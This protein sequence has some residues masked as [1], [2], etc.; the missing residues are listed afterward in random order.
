MNKLLSHLFQA[1][2]ITKMG[3]LSTINN[4]PNEMLPSTMRDSLQQVQ[5]K[6]DI[7]SMLKAPL[8]AF[9]YWINDQ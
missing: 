8:G 7:P 6:W 5:V 2:V 4:A 1:V 3:P 9:V